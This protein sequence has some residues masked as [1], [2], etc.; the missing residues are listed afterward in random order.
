MAAPKLQRIDY[1]SM[2]VSWIAPKAA[3]SYTLVWDQ[4]NSK[5]AQV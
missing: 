2:T 4:G 1:E 5:T 3:E